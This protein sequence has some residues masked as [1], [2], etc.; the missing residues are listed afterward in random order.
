MMETSILGHD[1]KGC[2][3][4][5]YDEN[6]NRHAVSINWEG[7]V[8]EHGTQD[9]PLKREDRT[10]E[11]QRIMSQVEARARY[12]AQ[13]EFEDEDILDPMW[14]IK[15]LERGLKALSRYPLEDFHQ[16][17]RDFYDALRHPG[18]FITDGFDLGEVAVFKSFRFQDAEILDVAP[19]FV[20]HYTSQTTADDYGTKPHYPPDER[21][22]A[23]LP[24]MDFEAGY[25]YEDQFHDL[26]TG[27]LLAEI[28][29]CY[30][31]MGEMPPEE[32]QVEGIG[33]FDIHGDGTGDT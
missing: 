20:R 25:Q 17:F 15:H 22:V 26:V 12:A 14:D 33:K 19:V 21:I 1:E 23:C 28:R 27:H 11:Q 18:Q 24:P 8:F 31:H 6:G 32:Y 29:D 7:E 4:E 2:G 5:V 30:L 13:R 9:Y 16:Q 3:V 10:Q